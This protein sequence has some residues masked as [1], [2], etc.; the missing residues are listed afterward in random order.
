M[1]ETAKAISCQSRVL[2]MD[3]SIPALNAAEIAEFVNIIRKLRRGFGVTYISH[4]PA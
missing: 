1:A 2:I 3:E 4:V